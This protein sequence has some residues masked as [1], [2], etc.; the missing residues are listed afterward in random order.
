[1]LFYS[2]RLGRCM[3]SMMSAGYQRMLARDASHYASERPGV[4]GHVIRHELPQLAIGRML[5]GSLQSR[6][7]GFLALSQHA[8]RIDLPGLRDT[9]K[10][11]AAQSGLES[12]IAAEH[13]MGG[14]SFAR[15]SRVNAARSNLHLFGV[16]EGED[17]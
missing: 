3:L 11:A 12:M 4:G 10:S 6:A 2:L 14:R 15:G 1:V 17:D 9:T 16:V 8:E 7:L 5:G 13:V